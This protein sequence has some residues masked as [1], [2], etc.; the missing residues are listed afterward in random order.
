MQRA[1]L[2]GLLTLRFRILARSLSRA[3]LVGPLL[4]AQ[5][6][7]A[8]DYG[9]TA[10]VVRP[11]AARN[12][13]DATAA[14]TSI[15]LTQRP[16][17]LET[18]RDVVPEV[19]GAIALSNGGYGA[20]SSISLRGTD[21]AQ[22]IFL[23]GDVP[24]NGPDTGPFDLSLIPLP[25][26]SRL[27]VYRGGAPVWF[28]QGSIG[29]VVRVVPREAEGTGLSAQAGAASFGRYE[30]RGSSYVLNHGARPTAF[31][32]GVQANVV[33]NDFP[34]LDDNATRFDT[35]DDQERRMKNAQLAEG[36]GLL[37][38]RT[39]IFSGHLDVVSYALGRTG[40][41]PGS[42]GVSF[43]AQHAHRAVQR[44]LL[45]AAY[46]RERR[47]HGERRYRLQLLASGQGDRSQL[48]DPY[49]ELAL[50]GPRYLTQTFARV[51]GRAA[52]SVELT[53]FLEASVVLTYSGD[54]LDDSDART[55]TPT[56]S[57]LPT[58][59]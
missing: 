17:A 58:L 12:E 59:R 57:A 44:G 22:T 36:A 1:L 46:T 24:L 53:S 6:A 29:G 16:M 42:G 37:H 11:L 4:W 23:L 55:S 35:S 20:P 43:N 50:G 9:A 45:T 39:R 7:L 33:Q 3:A 52:A 21:L 48:D 2:G 8:Q 27:E 56:T 18:L 31:Y 32:S 5:A 15:E 49:S 13:E 30:L 41:A 34:Y 38:F 14:A 26:L 25:Q 51:T 47:R 19:P 54:R 40:G 10:K 28:G